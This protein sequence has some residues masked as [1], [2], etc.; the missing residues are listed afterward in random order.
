MIKKFTI[1]TWA[2]LL[3]AVVA[4]TGCPQ[5]AEPVEPADFYRGKTVDLINCAQ[6]G[7]HADLLTHIIGSYLARDTG[8]NVTVTTKVGA[9][10][11]EGMNYIYKAKPDGLTLGTA[12]SGQI[13]PN[14]LFDEPAAAYKIEEFTYIMSESRF[15]YYFLISPQGPC[16]SIADL[17]A[18]PNLKIGAGTPSG[19]FCLGSLLIIKLLDLDAKVVTGIVGDSDRALA[20]DRGELIGYLSNTIGAKASVEAGLVKPM[21][22]LTTER[23]PFV[24]DVPSITELVDFSQEDLTLVKLWETTFFHSVLLVAPPGIPEDRRDFLL[25]LANQWVQEEGFREEV[26]AVIGEEVKTYLIGEE[27]TETMLQLSAALSELQPIFTDLL[28]KYR[29]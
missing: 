25:D 28:E 26:N 7:R 9:G 2:L 29:A 13:V 4:V 22:M 6:P 11:V 3:A 20:V 17:Q 18:T 21:F 15:Q 1:I 14:K 5:P 19:A 24:P 23:D 10:G 16:Q 8:A 12:S 27:A